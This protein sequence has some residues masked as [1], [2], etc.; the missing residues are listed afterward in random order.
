MSLKVLKFCPT[1][2][3]DINSDFHKTYC[4]YREKKEKVSKNYDQG[5][6]SGLWFAVEYLVSDQNV[7]EVAL[8]MLRESGLDKKE[9]EE[10]LKL[11]DYQVEILKKEI[12]DK[13]DW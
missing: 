10:Q 12:L 4:P 8:G 13:W 11:T 5:F 1:C 3:H 9:F 7:P 6:V 2:E